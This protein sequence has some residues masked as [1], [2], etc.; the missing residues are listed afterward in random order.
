MSETAAIILAAGKST[1]MKSDAPKVLFDICGRPML[2]YVIGACR[3]AGVDRL[4]VVVGHGKQI[5]VDRFAGERDIIWA[6]QVEQ[7]GTGHAVA[8]CRGALKGFSGNVLVIAGDMPLVRR[9]TLVDLMKTRE[10]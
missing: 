8:C 9:E 1:R 5:V 10:H 2:G 6:E 4:V 3:L 7:K